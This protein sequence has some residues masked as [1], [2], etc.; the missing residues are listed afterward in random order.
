MCINNIWFLRTDSFE[1]NKTIDSKYTDI[2]T[3]TWP[4]QLEKKKRHLKNK[5]ISYI[6]SAHG[7]CADEPAVK[8]YKSNIFPELTKSPEE[9]R[10]DIRQIKQDLVKAGKL[11]LNEGGKKRCDV[12]IC[13]W[14]ADMGIGDIVFVRNQQNEVLICRITGYVLEDFFDKENAFAR[15]VAILDRVTE[16]TV[17]ANIW[18]R[19]KGR[20]ALE[21]NADEDIRTSVIKYMEDNDLCNH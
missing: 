16:Q 9:L 20:K 11:D 14:I 17:T 18:D 1:W 4:E 2:D 21:R 10:E 5:I 7:I 19:T 12:I 13:Y 3:K 6:Y 15:E 8:Q